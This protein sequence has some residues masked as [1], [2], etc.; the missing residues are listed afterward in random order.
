MEG[1]LQY[2]LKKI[3]SYSKDILKKREMQNGGFL[4][5]KEKILIPGMTKVLWGK[6]STK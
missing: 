2:L 6:K 3:N 5:V 1:T 4:D